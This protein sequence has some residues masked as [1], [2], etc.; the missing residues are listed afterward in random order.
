M[1]RVIPAKEGKESKRVVEVYTGTGERKV[2]E[3]EVTKQTGDF[4]FDGK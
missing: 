4:Y 3:I 2:E 1:F